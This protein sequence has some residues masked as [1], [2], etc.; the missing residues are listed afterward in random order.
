MYRSTPGSI[1]LEQL[2]PSREANAGSFIFAMVTTSV[3]TFGFILMS[4]HFKRP[5]PPSSSRCLKVRR[6]DF[7]RYWNIA[8]GHNLHGATR[9]GTKGRAGRKD[10]AEKKK[11]E[12]TE[13]L[14]GRETDAREGRAEEQR[15][16]DQEKEKEWETGKR[17]A[18]AKVT[19]AS[20][21]GRFGPV[22]TRWWPAALIA[23]RGRDV[24]SSGRIYTHTKARTFPT[25]EHVTCPA[26]P[27]ARTCACVP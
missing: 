24:A 2:K 25:H 6:I 4:L 9:E 23:M 5:T 7:R 1:V 19:E 14:A 15:E 18:R 17:R 16:K 21:P 22:G 11:K 13:W 8:R 26:R 20:W 3:F 27:Y 10:A 12:E